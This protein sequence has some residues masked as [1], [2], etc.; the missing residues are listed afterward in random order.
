M[1]RP[2]QTILPR[3]IVSVALLTALLAIV[4]AAPAGAAAPT[5]QL[6]PVVGNPIASPEPVLASNGRNELAYELQLINRTQSVVTIFSGWAYSR[7]LAA[8]SKGSA[9]VSLI[10][11]CQVGHIFPPRDATR[12]PATAFPPGRPAL[13]PAAMPASSG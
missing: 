3:T 12:L 8:E 1:L 7:S 13:R 4:F 2:R 6:T 5:E 10:S 11:A 9:I